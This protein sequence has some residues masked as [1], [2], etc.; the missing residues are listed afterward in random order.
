ML[1]EWILQ[2]LQ[3]LLKKVKLMVLVLLVNSLQTQNGLQRLLKTELKISSLVFAVT[4]LASTSLHQKVT[5]IHK[6]FS[7]QW[8]FLVVLLTQKQCSLKNI[9]LN[10]Q[11]NLRRLLLSVAVSVVWKLLLFLHSVATRLTFMKSQT[12]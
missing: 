5:L 10:L 7:T 12:N 11:R 4:V 2:L 3:M 8:V 1:V 6:T 9:K